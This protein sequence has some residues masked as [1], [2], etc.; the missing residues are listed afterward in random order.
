[1]W[2]LK[3]TDDNEL[4]H[5]ISSA[6]NFNYPPQTFYE[7]LEQKLAERK[8][9]DLTFRRIE[10]GEGGLTSDRRTYLRIQRERLVF[11]ICAAPFGTGYFFSCRTVRLTAEVTLFHLVSILGVLGLVGVILVQNLGLVIGPIAAVTLVLALLITLRNA[12][13]RNNLSVDAL[14]CRAPII[15]PVY[16]AFFKKET[17]Y[18]ADT[19]LM[20]LSLIPELVRELSESVTGAKGVR[21][22]REFERAPVLGELYHPVRPREPRAP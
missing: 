18:R 7:E 11:D 9:P 14:L 5:W 3:K 1:M 10:F 13:T 22:V 20:Y 19:R 2:P 16:E 12:G 17:Y 8:I 21:L 15:G 6:D 4:N